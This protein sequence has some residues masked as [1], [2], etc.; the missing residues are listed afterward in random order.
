MFPT[1]Q[2][3][4]GAGLVAQW[5]VEQVMG[6]P[7]EQLMPVGDQ[8]KYWEPVAEGDIPGFRGVERGGMRLYVR[9]REVQ[10]QAES[11]RQHEAKSKIRAQEQSLLGGNLPGVSLAP[12]HPSAIR[13]NRVNKHFEPM[14]VPGDD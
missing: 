13:S 4:H 12:N 14:I 9:P 8:R 2:G 7:I 11:H 3:R 5:N 6:A 1:F 10:A